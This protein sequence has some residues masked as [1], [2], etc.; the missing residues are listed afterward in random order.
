MMLMITT[1]VVGGMA[2]SGVLPM[3]WLLG[4]TH[5]GTTPQSE[6]LKVDVVKG[7]EQTLHVPLDVQKSLGIRKDGSE[8]VAVAQLPKQGII[9]ELP[10]STALDPTRLL[11]IR[12]RFAPAEVV[13]IGEKRD[14][15]VNGESVFREL[16]SG[17]R[18]KKGERLAIFYSVDVGSKKN[19]LYDALVQLKLDEEILDRAEKARG[20]VP[21]IFI[22]NAKRA[23][24]GDRNAITRAENTLRAWGIPSEDVDAIHKEAEQA[25]LD[26]GRTSREKDKEKEKDTRAKEKE[27]RDKAKQEQLERWARVELKA[28]FDATI[29][30][31]NVALHEIV[32]DATTN[33]FVLAQVDR[34]AVI[35]NAPE[36]DLPRLQQLSH[37]QR[38][39]TIDTV[40]VPTD[41][42]L[43]G[44]IDEI[45]YLIDPNQHTAVIK[46]YIN[47]ANEQ[48]RAGQFVTVRIELP[49]RTDVV[50][51]PMNAVVDDGKQCV[52]FVQPD[53][54]KSEFVLRRV[55][56]THRFDKTAYIRSDLPV[57]DK[58]T[59]AEAKDQG[60][61]PPE[62][63]RAGD[64]IITAGVLELKK[65]LEDREAATVT[66]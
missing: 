57:P 50:E 1:L 24:L 56:V 5:A 28:P 30:E 40:G 16:R 14:Q 33:L 25:D 61:R 62:P 26:A 60:V 11:R 41:K 52:V 17:D 39:W 59:R 4:E 15:P 66:Q 22:L 46:G 37:D 8:Q 21:E 58:K 7:K 36:D 64:R 3:G 23:V 32:V 53:P 31:R 20:T 19:D 13:K 55:I 27:A 38:R 49:K 35:A 6:R 54:A 10:G 44:T 12:A 47:N 34:L 48:I 51:V 29:V 63:L 45:G 43:E 42:K 65:E 9:L 2:V 18:V